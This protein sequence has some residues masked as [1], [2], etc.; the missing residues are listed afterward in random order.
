LLLLLFLIRSGPA[1]RAG[2]GPLRRVVEDRG[3]G[4]RE[5]AS[6]RKPRR[7]PSRFN[8][9]IKSEIVVSSKVLF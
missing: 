8:D 7:L 6:S 2:T 5:E 3:A 1:L 9:K 4:D